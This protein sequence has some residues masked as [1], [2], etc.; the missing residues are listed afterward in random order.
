MNCKQERR[1][2]ESEGTV[3]RRISHRRVGTLRDD[4]SASTTGMWHAVVQWCV[5][6]RCAQT[7]ILEMIILARPSAQVIGIRRAG[8]ATFD[9]I[10]A[11]GA[12]CNAEL[13][14][15][16]RGSLIVMFAHTCA[17]LHWC[18]R[19]LLGRHER[20]HAVKSTEF[21][22]ESF[23]TRIKNRFLE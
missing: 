3:E 2:E 23:G 21:Y 13:P 20:P 14:G 19:L 12:Q 11:T 22:R 15:H 16:L 5:C 1:M 18:L 10:E 6:A 9:K 8:R 4:K 7:T 17:R